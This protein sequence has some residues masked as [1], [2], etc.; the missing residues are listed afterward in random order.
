MRQKTEIAT[1]LII[2]SLTCTAIANKSHHHSQ[3]A[4]Q[5]KRIIK[6]LSPD[7]IAELEQGKGWGL[8]K[9]QN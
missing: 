5:E 3:Y 9:Q 1:I 2:L 7:D 4:G 6:S 8:A